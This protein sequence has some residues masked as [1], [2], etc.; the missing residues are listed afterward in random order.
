[1]NKEKQIEEMCR[2]IDETDSRICEDTP[3]LPDTTENCDKVSCHSCKVARN[4]MNAGYRK[5]SEVI[6][7]YTEAVRHIAKKCV[8][9]KNEGE[10]QV[11]IEM[12][13]DLAKMKGGE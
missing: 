2:I 11:F 12:L 3:F 10:K 5:Q 1:M 6:T 8:R 13:D 4:L 9:F 7:E